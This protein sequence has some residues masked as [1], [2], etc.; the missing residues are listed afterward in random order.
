MSGNF[1]IRLAP[2]SLVAACLVAFAL[3]CLAQEK[4]DTQALIRETQRMGKSRKDA[5]SQDLVIVW[6][7]PTEFW[8]VTLLENPATSMQTVDKFKA[9]LAPYTLV[10]VVRAHIG[11]FGGVTFEDEAAVRASVTVKD[12]Q[13]VSYSPLADSEVNPDA[14]NLLS[15][16]KPLISNMMGPMGQ[17]LDCLLFK[18]KG[19]GGHA[20]ADA[21]SEGSFAVVVAGEEFKFRLPL[22]SLMPPKFDADT[23]ERFPGNYLYS[24]FTGSKLVTAPAAADV[25]SSAP[26]SAASSK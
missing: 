14:K 23:H 21:K 24:P 20:I 5:G 3:P 26:D 4:F 11:A 13:G 10:M 17:N 2:A 9:T 1:L 16:M 25:A 12:L 8:E 6:W 7:V 18:T 15:M 22:G 19:K